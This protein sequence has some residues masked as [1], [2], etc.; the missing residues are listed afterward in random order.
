M[1]LVAVRVWGKAEELLPI[2]EVSGT[3]YGQVFR[4]RA[5]RGKDLHQPVT[6]GRGRGFRILDNLLVFV[7]KLCCVTV[8]GH[9]TINS[10]SVGLDTHYRLSV[11]RV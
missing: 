10:L 9:E 2:V 5:G 8:C 11:V 7:I 1:V 4:C 3:V 6:T